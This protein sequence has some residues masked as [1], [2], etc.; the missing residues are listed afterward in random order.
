MLY[1][2][3]LYYSDISSYIYTIYELLAS[4]GLQSPMF[5]TPV[6]HSCT[7]WFVKQPIK[8][9]HGVWNWF[10]IIACRSDFFFLTW[11]NRCSQRHEPVDTDE[12]WRG[13]NVA[14][15]GVSASYKSSLSRNVVVLP[16]TLEAN[17]GLLGVWLWPCVES[18]SAP[19]L[20][21][22]CSELVVIDIR[23]LR[24]MADQTTSSIQL[25]ARSHF[26]RMYDPSG[27]P[28]FFFRGY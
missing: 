28:L 20:Y 15:G 18:N 11:E 24:Q 19:D 7:Y 16:S 21:S 8:I 3:S 23:A 9:G 17:P 5:P 2:S 27:W 6:S 14:V 13:V 26:S 22:I 25:L 1:A 4:T 12:P 10:S